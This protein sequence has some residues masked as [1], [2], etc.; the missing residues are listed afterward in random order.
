MALIITETP[1]DIWIFTVRDLTKS[2]MER[3][4]SDIAITE[5]ARCPRLYT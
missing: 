1:K 3:K 2:R 5:L 4:N